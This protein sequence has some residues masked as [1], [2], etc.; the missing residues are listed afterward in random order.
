MTN[1]DSRSQLESESLRVAA[2]LREI[3]LDVADV[4]DLVNSDVRY[5]EAIPVL[6]EL[7]PE[8]KHPRMKE[9]IARALTVREACPQAGRLLL[10]EFVAHPMGTKS[11]QHGKWA[12]G[13]ALS[14]VADDSIFEQLVEV[15]QDGR[16]GW[17][18]SGMVGAL[19]RMTKNRGATEAVLSRL[20]E[21]ND[22][23][24]QAMIVSGQLRLA[25]LEDRVVPFLKHEDSWVGR[26]AEKALAR[27]RGR[28]ESK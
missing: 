14:V 8:V 25:S 10:S 17:A 12:L 1:S 5:P 11:E 24:T 16:H 3:G 13:N 2:A 19:A 26:Q 4:Y 21:D 27:I 15:V 9:G 7:L 22:T 18:R 23:A 28:T 6:M 20:L